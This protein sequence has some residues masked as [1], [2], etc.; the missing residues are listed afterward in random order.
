MPCSGKFHFLCSDTCPSLIMKIPTK[1]LKPQ[2]HKIVKHNDT[3][4]RQKPTNC[5]SLSDHFV[6]LTLK[7]L[8]WCI[9]SK[10]THFIP[11]VSFYTPLKQKRLSVVFREYAKTPAVL[12]GLT[13]KTK[14]TFMS[15]TRKYIAMQFLII[16]NIKLLF[17]ALQN[18]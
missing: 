12:N 13:I 17:S 7:E 15:W 18:F 4:S 10:L 3:I 16:A 1:P 5:L 6:G 2:L 11:L 9:C 14:T 8:T